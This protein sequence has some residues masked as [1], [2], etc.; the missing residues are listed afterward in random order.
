[1]SGVTDP[2][3]HIERVWNSMREEERKERDARIAEDLEQADRISRSL[4]ADPDSD[5]D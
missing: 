2:D 3:E 1:V 5:D 4:T